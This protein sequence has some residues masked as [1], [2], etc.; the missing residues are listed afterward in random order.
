MYLLGR[1]SADPKDSLTC[2]KLATGRNYREVQDLGG[3]PIQFYAAP[4]L[5]SEQLDMLAD[6]SKVL[7][8]VLNPTHSNKTISLAQYETIVEAGLTQEEHC[9]GIVSAAV[10]GMGRQ[11]AVLQLLLAGV[12]ALLLGML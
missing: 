6:R 12:S 1:C 10:V 5:C 11:G 8:H 4:G 2:H 9:A 3:R 7:E